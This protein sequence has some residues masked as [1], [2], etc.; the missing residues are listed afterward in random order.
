M[1]KSPTRSSPNS[2]RSGTTGP[3]VGNERRFRAARDAEERRHRP[4][5]FGDQRAHPLGRGFPV[6]LPN[7]KLAHLPA[8]ARSWRQRAERRRGT[9]VVYADRFI[10]DDERRRSRETGDEAIAI[11]FLKRFTVFN[12]AQCDGLPDDL[13][14]VPPPI[15]EGLIIPEVEALIRASGADLR[16]GGD[17]AFY[18][19]AP[20]T[21]RCHGPRAISSRSTG[22][23]RPCTNSATGPAIP[24]G[25]RGISRADSARNPTRA[26]SCAPK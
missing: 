10:P 17:R 11:P 1:R 20:T 14:A 22:I 24:H 23:A 18:A 16:L 8:G 15:P 9:T 7:A 13:V 4:R 2:R 5:I 21:S 19:P 12:A 3:A 26:R 6:W 25:S